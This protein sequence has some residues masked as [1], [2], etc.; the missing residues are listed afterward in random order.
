M[1]NLQT[2]LFSQPTAS[3]SPLAGVEEAGP[4]LTAAG[5]SNETGLNGSLGES[6]VESEFSQILQQSPDAEEQ[7]AEHVSLRTTLHAEQAP[8]D[9]P[10]SP[11]I[12]GGQAYELTPLDGSILPFFGQSLPL[13]DSGAGPVGGLDAVTQKPETPVQAQPKSLVQDDT[14][15][16]I[17]DPDLAF[18]G[19]ALA[20]PSN[21][22]TLENPIGQLS[23]K[24]EA[25]VSE[26]QGLTAAGLA[27]QKQNTDSGESLNLATAGALQ[28]GADKQSV[29]VLGGGA[30]SVDELSVATVGSALMKSATA[31]RGLVNGLTTGRFENSR[32]VSS[33][34]ISQD[35]LDMGSG[36]NGDELQLPRLESAGDKGLPSALSLT[37]ADLQA[38]SSNQSFTNPVVSAL[39][40]WKADQQDSELQNEVQSKPGQ[41]KISVPFNQSGWGENLGRQL[42]LLMA[43][44]MDSAQIQLDPPEL[45]PLQVKIQINQDQ[46]SLQFN[47]GHAVVREALE[48]SSQRLQQMFSDEGLD[49]LDVT[50]TDQQTQQGEGNARQH[51][52][53]SDSAQ[54]VT[55]RDSSK[56]DESDDLLTL[57]RTVAVNDGKIDYFI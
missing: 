41:V 52:G 27:G 57:A 10:E 11:F 1:A 4:P 37:G 54:R 29:S 35:T 19:V 7:K 46:V 31:P 44:N 17:D 23:P 48:Q 39:S 49:L 42:T 30:D 18:A 28:Q 13:A 55:G 3:G 36:M 22:Q 40:Q 15:Q 25:L 47:S 26:N 33:T 32:I 24:S 16:L 34:Q 53:E 6:A 20:A 45:G 50:V 21:N 8:L 9:S 43:R 12:L 2:L 51:Q 14:Q 5:G 38:N 56:A